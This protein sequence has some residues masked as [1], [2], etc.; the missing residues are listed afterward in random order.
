MK[1]VRIDHLC[2]S[3]LYDEDIFD[4]DVYIVCI[5]ACPEA[6]CFRR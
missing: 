3:S 4:C 6:Y 5:K 2:D 1:L